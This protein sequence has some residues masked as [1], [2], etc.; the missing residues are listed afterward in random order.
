M[1][2]SVFLIAT[3]C[4]VT[5]DTQ[6]TFFLFFYVYIYIMFETLLKLSFFF[7][8][9]YNVWNSTGIVTRHDCHVGCVS[10]EREIYREQLMYKVLIIDSLNINVIN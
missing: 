8:Y 3:N 10:V 6:Q 2:E 1:L 9:I 5:S 7:I 4:G